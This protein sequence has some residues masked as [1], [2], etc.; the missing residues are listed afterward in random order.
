[1]L[2]SAAAFA[3]PTALRT[4]GPFSAALASLGLSLASLGLSSR[5][6]NVHLK[7]PAIELR[8]IHLSDGFVGVLFAVK[9]DKPEAAGLTRLAIG[10]DT[11]EGDVPKLLTKI[12]V[13][14]L[15]QE[16]LLRQIVK[17]IKAYLAESVPQPIVICI[18]A[19]AANK[20]FVL[21]HGDSLA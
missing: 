16:I 3:A 12:L 4:G 20:E 13:S 1:V 15:V 2:V 21:S 5:Q 18:P 11:L 6:R 19:K 7:V 14:G 17:R 8:A 10:A 9:G